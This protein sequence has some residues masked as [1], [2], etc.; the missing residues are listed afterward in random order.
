MSDTTTLEV[1]RQIFA[2]YGLPELI[3][4]DNGPQFLAKEF[5]ACTTVNGIN[6]VLSVSYHPAT[7]GLVGRFVQTFKQA[8]KAGEGDGRLLQHRLSAFL[9]SY[10][11]TTHTVT[12][13]APRRLFLQ[14]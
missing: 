1:L 7:N 8:M 14:R 2:V 4:S 5:K 13:E 9:L 10:F 11:T 3:I 6:H 12:N